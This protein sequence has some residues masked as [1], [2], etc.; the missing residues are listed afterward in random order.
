MEFEI[1][2]SAEDVDS[3]FEKQKKEKKERQKKWDLDLLV[4]DVLDMETGKLYRTKISRFVNRYYAEADEPDEKAIK[5]FL[6]RAA[7]EIDFDFD[8]EEDLIYIRR[9]Q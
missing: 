5:R 9:N 8:V 3:I 2:D 4:R 6:R 7:K 1:V